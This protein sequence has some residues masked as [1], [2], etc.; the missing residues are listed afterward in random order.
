[1][2]T[3]AIAP[4]T[5]L[6]SPLAALAVAAACLA[7]CTSPSLPPAPDIGPRPSAVPVPPVVEEKLPPA[8][9]T[10]EGLASWYTPTKKHAT[11]ANGEKMA[12]NAFTAAHRSLPMDTVVR[13][14]NLSNGLSVLVRINDRGPFIPGRVIDLSPGAATSLGMKTAGVAPVRLEVD[15]ADQPPKLL[16]SRT[17]MYWAQP[18]F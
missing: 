17:A 18:G 15:D 5:R 9:Y 1:M 10:E 8:Y 14:T 2:S 6:G 16:P 7:A 4:R 13:V 3:I 12:K 11:T